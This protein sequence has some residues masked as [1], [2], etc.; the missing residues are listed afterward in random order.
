MSPPYKQSVGKALHRRSIYSVWKRTAPLPNMMAFDATTR[1]VCAVE[2]SRTN[3]PMQALVLLN[4]IQFVEAARVLAQRSIGKQSDYQGQLKFAF[5]T[6]TGRAPDDVETSALSELYEAQRKHYAAH[7]EEAK[8]L[9]S[10]GEAPLVAHNAPTDL[11]ALT[12]V[13]QAILNLD[14]TIWKR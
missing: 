12:T 4:D 5:S 11:A 6:L 3:T 2:R 10:Q 13:N 8:K 1:E 9:I 14:I 7:P